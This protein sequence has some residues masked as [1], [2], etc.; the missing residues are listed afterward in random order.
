[1]A[2]SKR[3]FTRGFF[4]EAGEMASAGK[5]NA[6]PVWAGG[7]S[8]LVQI[9]VIVIVIMA[10][11]AVAAGTAGQVFR[12]RH[13]AEFNRLADVLLDEVLKLVHFLLR[14]EEARRDGIL[15]QR[16]AVLL[17][18]GDFRR[19]ERLATML[20]FLE[21]LALVHQAFILAARGGVGEEGVNA[22]LDAAGF[23]V[24]GDGFAKL[25]RFGFN[26]VGHKMQNV[27]AGK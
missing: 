14:V 1:M 8:G 12:R 19:L 15:E 3:S 16:V 22:L 4:P 6:P 11:A 9:S 10:A 7:A 23:D 21:R 20:F 24:F 25:A 5:Q 26:F 18:R 17:K 2:A 27:L 13:A